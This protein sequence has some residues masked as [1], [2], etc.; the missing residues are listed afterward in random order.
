MLNIYSFCKPTN[1]RSGQFLDHSPNWMFE[2]QF[3]VG[4]VY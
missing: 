3:D 1:A 2:V 4:E